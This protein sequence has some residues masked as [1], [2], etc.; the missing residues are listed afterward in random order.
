MNCE[1]PIISLIKNEYKS[2]KSCDSVLIGAYAGSGKIRFIFEILV[3]YAEKQ[4]KKI[5]YLCH[6]T[7]L[8]KYIENEYKE[9][10]V[11]KKFK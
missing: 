4:N 9:F 1:D 10:S 7:E 11:Q 5:L 6:R 3:P 2:W 8:R